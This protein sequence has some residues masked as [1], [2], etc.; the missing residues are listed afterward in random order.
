MIL[1][2]YLINLHSYLFIFVVNK[3]IKT[4]SYMTIFFLFFV[5]YPEKVVNTR[6]FWLE[7]GHVT[8]SR[9]QWRTQKV[10]SNFPDTT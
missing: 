9:Q 10:D 7:I 6:S 8:F 5:R 1:V 2:W 4:R 3:L